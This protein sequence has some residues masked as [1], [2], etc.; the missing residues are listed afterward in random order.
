[1]EGRHRVVGVGSYVWDH[2]QPVEES[3][4]DAIQLPK[5]GWRSTDWHTFCEVQRLTRTQPKQRQLTGGSVANTIKGLSALGAT[6]SLIG[7]VGLDPS[8]DELLKIM[9]QLGIITQATRSE[10]PT[11]HIL[12]LVTPDGARSFCAFV[13]S[14]LETKESDLL[15]EYFEKCDLVHIE[16]YLIPNQCVIEKAAELAKRYEATVSYDIGNSQL[17]ERY[18]ERL[19][20]FLSHY[21]DI[22]FVDLDESFAL[23][24]LP[25]KSAAEFLSYLCPVAVVKA[26]A[27]GCYAASKGKLVHQPAIPTTIVDTTGAGDLFASGFLFS[28]LEG[29]SLEECALFGN[30]MGSAAIETYGAEIP[31]ARLQEIAATLR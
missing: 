20:A 22:L 25:P 26:G 19:W 29:G 16:G 11:S 13:Q 15:P 30:L 17:G 31:Q 14:E 27:D 12:S 10:T 8:G 21:V 9:D 23:T 1:M 7:N 28:F 24:H 4:L 3:F 18:R 2:I 6:C 5:R